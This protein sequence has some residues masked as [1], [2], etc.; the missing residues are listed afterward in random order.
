[1]IDAIFA[2][3]FCYF[4][5]QGHAKVLYYLEIGVFYYNVLS[6]TAEVSK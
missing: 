1:M 3:F 4:R 2:S 6:L 5:F